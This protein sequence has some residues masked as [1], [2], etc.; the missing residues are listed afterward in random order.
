MREEE[1]GR[2]FPIHFLF[3]LFIRA[4]SSKEGDR[5]SFPT[6]PRF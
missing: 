2:I 3:S 1:L 5:S 4:N 6:S